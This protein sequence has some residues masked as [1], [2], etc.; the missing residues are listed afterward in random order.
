MCQFSHLLSFNGIIIQL[1]FWCRYAVNNMHA[2]VLPTFLNG[3]TMRANIFAG[4]FVLFCGTKKPLLLGHKAKGPPPP[5]WLT[6]RDIEWEARHKY[7]ATQRFQ[8]LWHLF[9]CHTA[10]TCHKAAPTLL[11]TSLALMLGS[12]TYPEHCCENISPKRTRKQ[13][14]FVVCITSINNP[15]NADCPPSRP[16]PSSPCSDWAPG[17]PWH[18]RGEGDGPPPHK[19]QATS[20]PPIIGNP[21]CR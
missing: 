6:Q 2:Y 19:S 15:F 5:R 7:F 20:Q 3:Q 1:A 4:Q 11:S 8:H 17:P 16:P 9:V 12:T 10:I 14:V 13:R 18:M 21:M